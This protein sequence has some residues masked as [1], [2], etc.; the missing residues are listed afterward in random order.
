MLQILNLFHSFYLSTTSSSTFFYSNYAT[1]KWTR[2]NP[3]TA[4]SVVE[5]PSHICGIYSENRP[6]ESQGKGG[7]G[8]ECVMKWGYLQAKHVPQPLLPRPDLNFLLF[9]QNA[10]SEM[11]ISCSKI[12]HLNYNLMLTCQGVHCRERFPVVDFSDFIP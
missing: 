1:P 7:G 8:V 6:Q 11:V 10:G 2:N 3:Y 5:T 4:I 9:K 12:S